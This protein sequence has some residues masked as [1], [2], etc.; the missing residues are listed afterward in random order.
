MRV[1]FTLTPAFNP[2]GGGVQRTTFKLGRFF[3]ENGLDVY[4]FSFENKGNIEAEYGQLSIAKGNG[5]TSNQN[6]LQQLDELLYSVQPH[7]VINQMPYDRNLRDTLF[8]FREKNDVFLMGCLRNSLFNFK[9]NIRDRMKSGLPKRLFRLVDNKL[10]RGAILAYH[11]SKH[12]RDL[13]SIIDKHDRFVLLAPP[14]FEELK[15]FVG[16]YKLNKVISIPNSIPFVSEGT[17]HKEKILLHVGRLNV[18]QKR[19]DL[20]LPVWERVYKKLPDWKFIV[21]GDGD[22]KSNLEL[23]LKSKNLP[24]VNLLGHQKPEVY[25]KQASIFMMPSAFEGF[26]NTLIEAQSFGCVPVAFDSYAA[27]SW[28][29]NNDQDAILVP[30]FDVQ[31]MADIIVELALDKDRLERLKYLSLDNANRFTIDQVGKIWLDY[32]HKISA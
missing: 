19:S 26:P 25:Y 7:I 14:N 15:Y 5:R 8:S 3:Q 13:R 31:R 30:P 11:K 21:V 28:I 16:N 17:I 4:Y 12:G 29:A 22:F 1:L 18:Q 32:F 2:N 6:N 9:N 10:G 23:E 20:L 24:R 27:L